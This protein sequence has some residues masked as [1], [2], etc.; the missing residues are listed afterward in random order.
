MTFFQTVMKQQ[1][2][3]DTLIIAFP[4]LILNIITICD[5]CVN[6]YLEEKVII[7]LNKDESVDVYFYNNLEEHHHF[8]N[9]NLNAINYIIKCYTQ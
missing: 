3:V 5:C 7:K 9:M 8:D 6:I 1:I 4:E 2:F